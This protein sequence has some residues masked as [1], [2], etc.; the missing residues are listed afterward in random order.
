[1][2]GGRDRDED[3]GQEESE[4]EEEEGSEEE[5]AGE[6]GGVEI[7]GR[8]EGRGGGGGIIEGGEARIGVAWWVDALELVVLRVWRVVRIAWVWCYDMIRL[9]IRLLLP[10]MMMMSPRAGRSSTHRLR[11]ARERRIDAAARR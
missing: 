4:G 3:D 1:M 11:S 9:V 7:R 10:M 5:A 6:V 2:R 8:G